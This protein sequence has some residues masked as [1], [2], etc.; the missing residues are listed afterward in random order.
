MPLQTE[1]CQNNKSFASH[2]TLHGVSL[3]NR[4]D[5]KTYSELQKTFLD[6]IIDH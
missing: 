6:M 2:Q 5:R 1:L 4:D 3:G